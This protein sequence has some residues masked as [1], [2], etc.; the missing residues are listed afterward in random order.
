MIEVDIVGT[1]PLTTQMLVN[2]DLS[3]PYLDGELSVVVRDHRRQ[4]F[5]QPEKLMARRKL[6]IAYPGPIEYIKACGRL[7]LSRD[8]D[9]LDRNR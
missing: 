2:M 3:D 9:Y 5:A 1:V 7:A 8:Q 4:D 6:T